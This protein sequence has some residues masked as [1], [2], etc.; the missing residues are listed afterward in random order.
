VRPPCWIPRAG[1]FAA[2][3]VRASSIKRCATA[4]GEGAMVV[5]FVEEHFAREE[6][7]PLR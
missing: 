6:I 2:G 3:D 4:V 5:R 7:E 1:V